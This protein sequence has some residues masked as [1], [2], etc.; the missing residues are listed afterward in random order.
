LW[1]AAS[2]WSHFILP[3][4]GWPATL[5]YRPRALSREQEKI[6]EKKKAWSTVCCMGKTSFKEGQVS[7]GAPKKGTCLAAANQSP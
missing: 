4:R 7:K 5:Q 2:R 1:R 6:Q 3:P